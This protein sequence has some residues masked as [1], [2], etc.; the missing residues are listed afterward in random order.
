MEQADSNLR[1]FI[2][3]RQTDENLNSYLLVS[4]ITA[5]HALHSLDVAH[6]DIKPEN[7]LIF[8]MNQ[9]H[10]QVKLCDV[11]ISRNTNEKSITLA[12]GTPYYMAPEIQHAEIKTKQ[13]LHQV[14]Y[15][16]KQTFGQLES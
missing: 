10:P 6:C 2:K 15:Y 5:I 1:D 9:Q 12:G 11:G 13:L 7:F 8:L 16:S 3:K 14:N 4:I